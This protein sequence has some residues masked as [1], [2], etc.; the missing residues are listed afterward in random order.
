MHQFL[1][2]VKKEFYHIL[3]DR[4]TMVILL[5]LPILMLILFGYA[6]STEVKNTR[7]AVVDPSKDVV[8]NAIVEKFKVN[9]YFTVAAYVGD[10]QQVEALFNSGDIKMVLV[11]SENFHENLMHKGGAQIGI[12]TDGSDPNSAKAMQGYASSIIADYQQELF[13]ITKVPYQIKPNVRLLYN[14]TMKGAYN[15][16]PGVMGMILMLI[17]AMMTSISIAREKETG[18]MEIL[19]VSPLKPV[20]I[21]FSKTIPYFILSLVNLTTILLLSVFVLK[22]PVAG[23]LFALITISLVYIFVALSLGLLI[24]SIV[25]TQQIALLIS[26]MVLMLPIIMLSGMMFPVENM[27]VILQWF[28]EII[29]TKWYIIAVKKIMIKGLG[30]A[31]IYKEMAVLAGMG[32]L[33]TV[34]SLKKFKFRLE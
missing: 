29:P 10:F 34:V 11:F 31:A 19:L 22:V 26:G 28:S 24:S 27:P 14:P 8:T 2:F 20:Y 16:V 12:I 1:A 32:I 17:C 15:F 13:N 23:S 18:T 5:V 3:R 30:F 4:W 21:I 7:I 33:L 6:I 9:E 25:S